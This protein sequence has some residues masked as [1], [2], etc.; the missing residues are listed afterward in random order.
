MRRKVLL[1]REEKCRRPG[2][3]ICG[4]LFEGKRKE[5]D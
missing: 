3:P 2:L 5:E 1:H 4:P